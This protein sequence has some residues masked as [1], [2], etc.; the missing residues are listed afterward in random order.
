MGLDAVIY[1][2]IVAPYLTWPPERDGRFLQSRNLEVI[3]ALPTEDQSSGP[4]VRGM[5][6]LPTWKGGLRIEQVIPFGGSLDDDAMSRDWWNVWLG[7]FE[8]LLRNLYWKS[9]VLHMESLHAFNG[10][11]MFRWSPTECAA[12][13]VWADAPQPIGEWNRTVQVLFDGQR[14]AQ[15]RPDRRRAA[16]AGLYTFGYRCPC[17]ATPKARLSLKQAAI[18]CRLCSTT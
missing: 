2:R 13:L 16:T 18:P 15:G 5:F 14:G 10:H 17:A 11:R 9:V 4:L 12:A 6:A 7:K 1:G 3:A 8:S